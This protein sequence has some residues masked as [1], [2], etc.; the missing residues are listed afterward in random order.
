MIVQGMMV[1]QHSPLLAVLLFGMEAIFITFIMG[2]ISE[3]NIGNSIWTYVSFH[4]FHN[5]VLQIVLPMLS[6]EGKLLMDDGGYLLITLIGIA[7]AITWKLV[8]IMK[9][10][11]EVCIKVLIDPGSIK[12]VKENIPEDDNE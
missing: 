2:S 8:K 1:T 6:E 7:A 10:H 3:C 11:E 9:K 12:K 4:A 5:I